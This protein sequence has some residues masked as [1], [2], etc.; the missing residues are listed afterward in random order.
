MRHLR[1]LLM[2]VVSGFAA[3]TALFSKH[4]VQVALSFQ[5]G[6]PG[7]GM[8]VGVFTPD[9]QHPQPLHLDG[10]TLPPRGPGIVTRLD[11][12]FGSRLIAAG[13]SLIPVV[14]GKVALMLATFGGQRGVQH[15][16][17]CRA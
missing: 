8:N 6:A 3:E 13:S 16:N 4:P 5:A 9:P 2:L 14:N 15:C 10:L 11:L 1:F 12:P 7:A 17:C